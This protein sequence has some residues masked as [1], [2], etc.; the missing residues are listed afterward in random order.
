[1]ATYSNCPEL[2]EVQACQFTQERYT[3]Y[4]YIIYTA[5]V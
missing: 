5:L 1:M 2:A 3:E 4:A